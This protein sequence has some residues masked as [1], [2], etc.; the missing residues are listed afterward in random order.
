MNAPLFKNKYRIP[1]ARLPGW[2]YTNP[3]GYFVTICTKDREQY[4]GSVKNGIMHLNAA[5][6]IAFEYWSRIPVFTTATLG[7]NTLSCRIICMVS[8]FFIMKKGR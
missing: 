7:V 4:F 5:G 1:S 2:D 6:K 8:F 3:G